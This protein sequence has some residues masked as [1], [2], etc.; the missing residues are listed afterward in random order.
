MPH[1]AL[2]AAL[3]C[4]TLGAPRAVARAESRR[5]PVP[6]RRNVV[7]AAGGGQRGDGAVAGAATG[8]VT[9]LLSSQD[10]GFG[11]SQERRRSA[12][13][14]DTADTLRR[15][16][17]VSAPRHTHYPVPS[18]VLLLVQAF[19]P[20]MYS[21]RGSVCSKPAPRSPAPTMAASNPGSR[22]CG[23]RRS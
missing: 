4:Q 16:I 3:G 17:A 10:E 6:A 21:A 23:I 9:D 1:L 19:T 14:R 12:V 18:N 5:R 11:L 22:S 13:E 15:T 20:R 7:V 8:A 2:G